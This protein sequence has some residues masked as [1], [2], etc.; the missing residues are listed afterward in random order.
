[1]GKYLVLCKIVLDKGSAASRY[2]ASH[3]LG[4]DYFMGIDKLNTN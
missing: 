2:T 3:M 4:I 1:M